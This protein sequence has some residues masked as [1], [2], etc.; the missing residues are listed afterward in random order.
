MIEVDG[1]QLLT[2]AQWER[3]RRHVKKSQLG[4]GVERAWV[5]PKGKTHAVF[6]S[7][8]Q[9]RPW[10]KRDVAKARRERRE[11]EATRKAK[12]EREMLEAELRLA[13]SEAADEAERSLVAACWGIRLPALDEIGESFFSRPHTAWQWVSRGLVPI[14]EARWRPR[15]YGFDGER[16]EWWYCRWYDV[17]PDASRAEKLLETGPKTFDRL[18][19]GR[20]YDGRPWWG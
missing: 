13:S 11:R 17:R 1:K 10:S 8:E 2:E 3:K 19:D 6:Y 20:P 5:C 18:P 14:A 4:K 16:S 15:S 7:L 9:T 12:A